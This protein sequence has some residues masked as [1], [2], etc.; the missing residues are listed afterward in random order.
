MRCPVY[1]WVTSLLLKATPAKVRISYCHSLFISS[2]RYGLHSAKRCIGIY[3]LGSFR[4]EAGEFRP[5]RLID[6]YRCSLSLLRC[7]DISVDAALRAA[8]VMVEISD[9]YSC[10]YSCSS[11]FM[12]GLL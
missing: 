4:M 7:S 1:H 11:A 9:C 8:W 2:G 10:F 5:L 12:D 3:F 6:I